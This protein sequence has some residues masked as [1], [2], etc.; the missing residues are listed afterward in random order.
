MAT[1]TKMK[2]N[3]RKQFEIIFTI[4]SVLCSIYSCW[5]S[6]FLN[7]LHG[8]KARRCIVDQPENNGIPGA[9]YQNVPERQLTQRRIIWAYT[10]LPDSESGTT[11]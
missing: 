1:K 3:K 8:G 11:P 10:Q 2:L 7:L 4:S 9:I 5:R 6:N